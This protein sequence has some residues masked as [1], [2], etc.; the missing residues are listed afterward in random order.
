MTRGHDRRARLAAAVA[1]GALAIGLPAPALPHP[2]GNVSVNHFAGIEVAP[3]EI[4]VR[5]LLDFAEIP[6]VRELERV[7]P[8]GDDLVTPEEREAYVE[9]RTAEVL[10]NLK[11]E[12][13]GVPR[14]LQAIWGHVT[15]PAGEGGLSTVRIAWELRAR[16][17]GDAAPET[18]ETTEAA[19]A[20]DAS[21][22]SEADDAPEAPDAA[23][24]SFLVWSD[25]NYVDR[26]GWKEI[27]FRGVGGIGIG[28]TSLK[29]N[30]SSS[31]LAEYP[32]EYLFD[33]P[34][35]TR[36]WCHFGPGL[37]PPAEGDGAARETSAEADGAPDFGRHGAKSRF[38]ALIRG[39]SGGPRVAIVSFLL[40]LL[41][42]AGHALEPGHG[43]TVVAAYLVGSRGTVAQAALLGLVVTFTHTFSVFVLGAGVLLLSEWVVPERLT[44]WL[45]V[46]SGI[47]IAAVGLTML[48]SRLRERRHA[49]VAHDHDHDH[50]HDHDHAHAHTHT[51]DHAHGTD[52]THVPAGKAT[53]G[54][55]LALGVSGGLVPCPAG[56]VVLLASVAQGR[57]LFGMLLI[58]AFSIGLAAVLMG[59]GILFVTAR[60]FLDRLPLGSGLIGRLGVASAVV[61][62]LFGLALA[63]R[64]AAGFGPPVG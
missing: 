1:L 24:R 21:D 9:A 20:A 48:R 43:K 45:G 39:E 13:N 59:I 60:R 28:R 26:D 25:D 54:S 22:A 36:A 55:I 38:A 58:A 32:E 35:D 18:A 34:R 42:G 64:S 19:E 44:P 16:L 50:T 11:L 46:L 61:V 47:L 31:E 4:S 49:R 33:P 10:G 27:R 52:H 37:E 30:L 6:S 41:L 23:D 3:G 62:T 53:L 51:H 57:V 56:V 63:W 29:R 40:A 14:E 12:V 5:Y 2:M 8:D 15:F 17:G 7:D